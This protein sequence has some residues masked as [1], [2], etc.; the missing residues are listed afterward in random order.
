LSE[1]TPKALETSLSI[2]ESCLRISVERKQGIMGID[3]GQMVKNLVTNV[4]SSKNKKIADFGSSIYKNMLKNLKNIS[5]R[6]TGG[7]N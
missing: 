3:E 1:T 6:N 7:K 4:L 5:G 2:V